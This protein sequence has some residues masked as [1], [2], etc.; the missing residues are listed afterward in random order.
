MDNL[1]LALITSIILTVYKIIRDAYMLELEFLKILE[2]FVSS[3]VVSFSVLYVLNT[4]VED[5]ILTGT[6]PF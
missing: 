6:P 1:Y 4:V 5:E 2:S 3:F